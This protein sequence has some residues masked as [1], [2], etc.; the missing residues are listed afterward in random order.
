MKLFTAEAGPAQ[1]PADEATDEG[2]VTIA[3]CELGKGLFAARPIAAGEQ[4]RYD[5][6]NTMWEADECLAV[7]DT[8]WAMR[9]RCG[10]AQCRGTVGEF[11]TL[12]AS[13][14]EHYLALGIVQRFIVDRM[15]R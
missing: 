10:S 9:C 14:R 15:G 2:T 5:Y 4:I 12:P 13:L 1:R 6:S 8:P 3:D 7:G 11:P